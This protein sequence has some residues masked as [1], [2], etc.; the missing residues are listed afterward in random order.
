MLRAAPVV[1]VVAAMLT[2]LAPS[3][4]AGGS[5]ATGVAAKKCSKHKKKHHKRRH[6]KHHHKRHCGSA[7]G[8]GGA[9]GGTGASQAK[10]NDASAP[11]RIG[12]DEREYSISP[13]M[14]SVGC[15]TTIVEQRNKGMDAHD[16]LAQKAGDPGP[17][18]VFGELGSG[19]V[20]EQTVNLSRGTWT[21]YCD[22]AE[23]LPGHR[24]LGMEV[25]VEVK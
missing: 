9:G 3:G 19:A 17:S 11:G 8:S 16:L 4:T 13:T 22:V 24:A 10:C 23:P 1:I 20:A 21:L 7:G 25:T 2:A 15:G 6:R 18:F 12:F 5:P 14:P